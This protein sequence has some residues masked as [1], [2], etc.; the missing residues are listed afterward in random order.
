MYPSQCESA[1]NLKISLGFYNDKKCNK[2][3]GLCRLFCCGG[4]VTPPEQVDLR[5]IYSSIRRRADTIPFSWVQ[6]CE[7][8]RDRRSGCWRRRR[9]GRARGRGRRWSETAASY[10]RTRPP[11]SDWRTGTSPS[12]HLGART[13]PVPRRRILLDNDYQGHFPT[14]V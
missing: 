11:I 12:G 4:K 3:N 6:P 8:G 9:G 7:A 5:Q 13:E 10:V 14:N 2:M 1:E